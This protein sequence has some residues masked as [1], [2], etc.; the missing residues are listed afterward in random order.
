MERAT[1]RVVSTSCEQAPDAPDSIR[2]PGGGRPRYARGR[3]SKVQQNVVKVA[4]GA[5]VVNVYCEL[6]ALLRKDAQ[7]IAH[8][9]RQVVDAVAAAALEGQVQEERLRLIHLL[10]GDGVPTNLAAARRLFQSLQDHPRIDYRLI[11]WVCASHQTNLVI[12]VAIC[13]TL[14][15]D[16]INSNALCGTCSRLFKYLINDY[17]EEFSASL[18]SYVVANCQLVACSEEELAQHRCK[19]EA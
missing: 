3:S 4:V 7:T 5:E 1:K 9:L 10:T 16:P 8:A 2:V 15:A 14:L 6:Q 17:F 13:G 18:R 11:V 12:Q 19:V